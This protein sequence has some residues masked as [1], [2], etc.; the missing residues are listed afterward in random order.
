MKK[1][2]I[3]LLPLVLF[4]GCASTSK[5]S[6]SAGKSATSCAAPSKTYN[7]AE[8]DNY[9]QTS[10][11]VCS[12]LQEAQELLAEANDFIADPATYIA[13]KGAQAKAEITSQLTSQVNNMILSI[14]EDVIKKAGFTLQSSGDAT[15]AAKNLPGMDK[16]KAAK[17]VK[18]AINN[19]KKAAETAPQ[20]VEEMKSLLSKL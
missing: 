7:S 9:L 2:I 15:N 10:Y 3:Y 5:S 14:A 17:D 1:V 6:D 12:D 20:I 4:V 11:D 13:K 8:L 19:L 16:L 18:A